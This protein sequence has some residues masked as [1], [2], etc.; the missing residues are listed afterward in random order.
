MRLCVSCG[1]FDVIVECDVCGLVG[2]W[3]SLCGV[4]LFVCMVSSSEK[5]FC[6]LSVS[7]GMIFGVCAALY[8]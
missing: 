1:S 8:R 5:V 2:C 3:A 6:S 7:S 4:V